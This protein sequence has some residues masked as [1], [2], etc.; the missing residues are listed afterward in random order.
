MKGLLAWLIVCLSAVFAHG[1]GVLLEYKD[2]QFFKVSEKRSTPTITLEVSG[3]AF[4]SSLAVSTIDTKIEGECMVVIVNLVPTRRGLSGNFI[5]DFDVPKSVNSVCFGPEKH[6][7]WKRGV[8]V[9]KEN[10]KGTGRNK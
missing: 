5:H 1:G 6:V 2:V 7:I 8:G 4:H 3:L 9:I 10:T